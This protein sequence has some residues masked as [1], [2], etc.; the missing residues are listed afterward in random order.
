MQ[1]TKLL[2]YVVAV[3]SGLIF[4]GGA[5]ADDW[6]V[7]GEFGWFGVGKA[8]EIEKGHFYWVGK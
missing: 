2:Q 8:Q 5:Q 1:S 6:K 4:W 3:C 7:T